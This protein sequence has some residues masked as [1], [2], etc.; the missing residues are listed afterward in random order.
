MRPGT[1]SSSAPSDPR[2]DEGPWLELNRRVFDGHPDQAH[3]T[4]DDLRARMAQPWFEPDDFLLAEQE[5]RI[6]AFNWVK[7]EPRESEGRVG[8]IYVVGVAPQAQGR[9]LG[10]LLLT[11]GLHRMRERH[12]DIAAIYVDESNTRAIDL[13]TSMD[14]HHHH[15]DVCYTLPLGELGVLPGET[16]A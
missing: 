4:E 2:S 9:G 7:I 13:Y 15:V 14:F 1:A 10:A 16:A 3:W 6:V 12:A 5:G 8:E 11:H